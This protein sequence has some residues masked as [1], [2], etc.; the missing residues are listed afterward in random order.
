MKPSGTQSDL[1][2]LRVVPERGEPL[3]PTERQE[4]VGLLSEQ[5]ASAPVDWDPRLRAVDE[6]TR[7]N[8]KLIAFYFPLE[9]GHPFSTHVVVDSWWGADI[10]AT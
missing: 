10:V 8:G 5:R 6:K 4:L 1:R 9:L 7:E 3:H 2:G